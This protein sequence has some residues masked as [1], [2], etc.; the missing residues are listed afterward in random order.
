MNKARREAL[1]NI[2]G[3]LMEITE[4]LQGIR[5]EEQDCLDNTPESFQG[6]ERYE[7]SENAIYEME[8][9]IGNLE[10]AC[11]SLNEIVEG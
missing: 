4:E 9:I 8:E 10:D 5:D 1:D 2:W 3:K 6:T 7:I 11:D